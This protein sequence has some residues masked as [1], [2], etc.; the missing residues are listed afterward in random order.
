LLRMKCKGRLL[1]EA[2]SSTVFSCFFSL[3]FLGQ[4]S[5]FEPME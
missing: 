3:L 5:K 2:L 4:S 1:D